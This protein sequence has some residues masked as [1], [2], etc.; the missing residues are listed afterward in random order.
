MAIRQ[1]DSW[2]D[3]VIRGTNS[4]ADDTEMAK[5]VAVLNARGKGNIVFEGTVKLAGS[6]T[7]TA[8]I[9]LRGL[10]G[11]QVVMSGATAYII[12]GSTAHPWTLTSY[13]MDTVTANN[14]S[15]SSP[16]LALSAGDYVICWSDNILADVSPHHPATKYRP[17]EI[18][19]VSRAVLGS[20]NT[21]ALGDYFDDALS[22]VTI[23]VSPNT[24]TIKPRIYKFSPIRGVRVENVTMTHDLN[25]AIS[26]T[27]ILFNYCADVTVENCTF[28]YPNG[29]QLG[30]RYTHGARVHG[31]RLEDSENIN[32]TGTGGVVSGVD[33]PPVYGVVVAVVNNFQMLGCTTNAMR[34]G[35]TTGGMD[36]TINWAASERVEVGEYRWYKNGANAA[37]GYECTVAGTTTAFPPIHSDLTTRSTNTNTP[38]DSYGVTWKDLGTDGGYYRYGGPKNVLVANN[39][40]R[41]TGKQDTDG[42]NTWR[43]LAFC[44]T[45]TEGRRIT[46]ANNV[47]TCPTESTNNNQALAIRSRDTVIRGNTFNCN[48]GSVPISVGGKNCHIENNTFNGGY[49]NFVWLDMVFGGTV[50]NSRWVGNTFRDFMSSAVIIKDGTGHQFINNNF[51]NCSYLYTS[52]YP[53]KSCVHVDELTNAS[54]TVTFTGNS[55]PRSTGLT[56]YPNDYAISWADT[57]TA[58]QIQILG[59]HN[60]EGYGDQ[61]IGIRPKMW[62]SGETVFFGET[63]RHAGR[64]YRVSTQHTTSTAPTHTSGTTNN[65]TFVRTYTAANYAAVEQR[66]AVNNGRPDCAISL[67][68]AH[69]LDRTA[70]GKPLSSSRTAV[71]DDVSGITRG[72]ILMDIVTEN[73]LM[74][75]EPGCVFELPSSMIE[76]GYDMTTTRL[77]FWD[78]SASLYKP[79]KPSDS[80]PASPPVLRVL[81]YVSGATSIV[82]ALGPE[83]WQTI[84]IP[85]GDETTDLTTGTAKATYRMPFAMKVW[86]VKTSVSTAPSGTTTLLVDVNEGGTSIL[87]AQKL[88]IDS[89]EKTSK[90]AATLSTIADT[91]LADDAEITID[92][93]AV[94]STAAGKGLKVYL[95]GT[96]E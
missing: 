60:F 36:R 41:G 8:P 76:T 58:N 31:L 75:A 68:T 67:Y 56:T 72:G 43:A 26:G 62:R 88:L 17:M 51:I 79:T 16:N 83:H 66:A 86:G 13:A 11:S 85:V 39:E 69:G 92:I 30:F 21:Y 78:A 91:S 55:M 15:I 61:S 18:H 14:W 12:Y 95:L 10:P 42:S 49:T 29:G 37:R 44:D 48:S 74:I 23:G 32:V 90:T 27:N 22:D 63:R 35:F 50:D 80:L 70:I 65:W 52:A 20:A 3:Y 71:F 87:G 24:T 54:S 9:G 81:G 64:E 57:I 45:H 59:G 47:F 46:I 25:S 93:D 38:A 73:H 33:V 34:H 6:Y 2:N 19:R 53:L 89:T 77:L 96:I 82:E 4:A 1:V 28:A 94:G 84:I 40:F 7:L 5:A